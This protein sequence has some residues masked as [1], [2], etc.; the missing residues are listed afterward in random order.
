MGPFFA[1]G[2]PHFTYHTSGRYRRSMHQV[3]A[4]QKG[5]IFYAYRT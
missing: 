5:S 3:F 1:N 4:K 2:V